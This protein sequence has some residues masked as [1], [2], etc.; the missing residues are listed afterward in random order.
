MT[1]PL[2]IV[3]QSITNN[4][5][6]STGDLS[7]FKSFCFGHEGRFNGQIRTEWFNAPNK[8]QFGGPGT[9]FGSG[10]FGQITSM[11]GGDSVRVI[12]M[13]AKFIF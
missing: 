9:S 1:N 8:P 5:G 13:A 12:Q 2:S 11:G 10:N 6:I 4:P 3:I 7:L